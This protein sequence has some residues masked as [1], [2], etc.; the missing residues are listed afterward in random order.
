MKN[1]TIESAKQFLKDKGYYIDNLWSIED[2]KGRYECTDEQAQEVLDDVLAGEYLM[3]EINVSI[4][5]TASAMDL[6]EIKNDDELL[7]EFEEGE[8]N[9][10]RNNDFRS[11]EE[12]KS[13]KLNS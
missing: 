3:G 10:F 5:I 4:G 8:Q 11:F 1:L 7:E 9:R 13:D 2:V 12:W 6:T